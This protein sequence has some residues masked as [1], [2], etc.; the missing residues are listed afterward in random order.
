[1]NAAERLRGALH[2]SMRLNGDL[3]R[4]QRRDPSATPGT[5]GGSM[6]TNRTLTDEDVEAIAEVMTARLEEKFYKNLGKGVWAMFQKVAI[7]VIVAIAAWGYSRG[8]K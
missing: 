4:H 1:M 7:V 3:F 8:Y 2:Q 5:E 6:G